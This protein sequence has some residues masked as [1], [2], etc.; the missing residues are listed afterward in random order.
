MYTSPSAIVQLVGHC[1]GIARLWAQIPSRLEFFFQ[2]LILSNC[3]SCVNDRYD[4]S[5]LGRTQFFRIRCHFERGVAFIKTY[6]YVRLVEG[7]LL[8]FIY[9]LLN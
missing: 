2:T 9:Y 3:L 4:Q 6:H 5:Q 1:T 8:L 7:Y